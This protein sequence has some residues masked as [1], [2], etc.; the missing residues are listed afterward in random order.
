MLTTEEYSRY[1]RHII[2]PEIGLEGQEK[3]KQAKV[4]VIGAGGLGCPVLIYLAAAG[5]GTIGI[6][7]FDIVDESNLHRQILYGTSDIGKSKVEAAKA[8]LQGQN[9]HI[10]IIV[11]NSRL[12]S[13]N[14]LDIMDDYEI[15]VDGSD[16]FPTRYLVND[17]CVMQKKPFVFGSIFKFEAQISTFNYDGGPTYR[18][19][20]PDPPGPGEAPSCAEIGVMGV[21]PGIVGSIQANEAIKIITG[22]GE[23]LSGKLL[24]FDAL[25]SSFNELSISPIADNFEISELIDYKLFCGESTEEIDIKEISVEELRSRL[26]NAEDIQI[27]DVREHDEYELCNLGGELI[28]LGEI[29]EKIDHISTQKPVVV[30]CHH[31]MRSQKAIEKL[32]TNACK[33]DL[34]NLKGGIHDW[35]TKIDLN[36]PTY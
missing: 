10:N 23:P 18:C 6:V 3:L 33:A 34:Y 14:A 12:T 28:P 36:M 9:P 27:I 35:A 24:L 30:H 5:V 22:A 19:L 7:D 15:I 4:L 2:L 31:G 26:N 32:L 16:N 29:E 13:Q 11:H 1:N 21:L 25:S 8:K 20:Y 17:A